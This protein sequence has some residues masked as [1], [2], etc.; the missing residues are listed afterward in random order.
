M[1]KNEFMTPRE[2]VVN[3][4]HFKE[5]DVLPW[6]ESF[7]PDTVIR[8][9]SEGLPAHK[10]QKIEWKIRFARIIMNHPVFGDHDLYSFFGITNLWGLRVPVD[11]GPI[12]RFKQ[13]KITETERYEEYLMETGARARRF[14][15][16]YWGYTMPQ[17][18][19]FPVKDKKSWEQYKARLDPHDP[20]RYPL[21]WDKDSYIKIFEE[22]QEG[23][24]MLGITGFYGFGAELMG[25]Q[26]FNISFYKNPDLIHEMA[27]YWEYFTIERLRDAVETLKDRIDM[28]Y[29]WED[30][31]ERHGPNIS[32]KLYREFLYP[33]YKRVI[34][35][36]KKNHIDRVMMDSDGNTLPIL[37]LAI[38]V[39]ITGHWPLEVNAGMDVRILRKMFGR[40]LFLAGNLDKREIAKG[41]EAMRKEVDSKLLFMKES[42]G[43]IAGLDHVVPIDISL[44]RF[45]EYADYLK[46]QLVY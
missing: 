3:T 8:W 1:R 9:F 36:L 30:M 35:F 15:N 41:G 45:K 18:I 29:W 6:Y 23:S 12:P 19:E 7:P 21:D 14:K 22:F 13:V 11:E 16:T 27:S 37:N 38:E 32:P 24:T 10:T 25:I 5:V 4:I 40:K 20:R 31:A 39:G 34:D 26:D 2:R 44:E 17:F 42:G 46:K 28:V 43:Y 33:H